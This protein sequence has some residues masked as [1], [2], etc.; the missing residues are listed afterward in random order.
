MFGRA[1]SRIFFRRLG[2]ELIAFVARAEEWLIA[3]AY[4]LIIEKPI[5]PS[6]LNGID[7]EVL[8]VYTETENRGKGISTQL[9]KNLIEY[10]RENKLCRIELKATD[11][12][13]P[14]Y[15]KAGFEDKPQKYLDICLKL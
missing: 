9:M 6:F 4:L 15:R 8:S 10:A 12:G 14:I 2:K 7:G 5:N 3:M 13:Y 1:A 11:K